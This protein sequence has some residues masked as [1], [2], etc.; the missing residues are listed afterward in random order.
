MLG[1]GA[2]AADIGLIG[3]AAWLISKASEHPNE[4]AIALAIVAV[5]F[6]GL[7]RGLLRYGQRLVGHDAAFRLLAD[8]RVHVYR[9]LERLAPGGLPGFRRGD[10]LTRIVR[11]VDSLQDLVIRVVPS[12]GSALLV[13]S[14]TVTLM[15]WLLPAA[16]IILAVALLLGALLVPWLT[17]VLA[18]RRE[19][20]FALARGDL[21]A[22]VVDLTDGAAELTAFGAMESQL[23]EIRRCDAELTAIAARSAGTAGIGLDPHHTVGGPGVLGLPDGRYSQRSPPGGWPA[24][25]SP[26]S[27]SSHL[28]PSNWSSACRL[29][30]R[31]CTG[32]ARAPPGSSRSPTHRRPSGSLSRPWRCPAGRST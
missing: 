24:R 23:D 1:A 25:I 2:L 21:A 18:R 30:L 14:L 19:F 22:A 12:F 20:H 10:L 27:H 13:G 8:L 5:Q 28:P 17:S 4:S 29:R 6:F 7:S 16:G 31:H 26:S 11:D 15:W 32:C 3:T 9:H